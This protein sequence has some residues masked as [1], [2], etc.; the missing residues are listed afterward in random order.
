MASAIIHLAVCK[1][2]NETLNLNEREFFLGGIAPDAAKIVGVPRKTTHFCTDD[3]NSPIIN[4]FMKKYNGKL[5]DAFSIGFFV[6]LL[7]DVLWF[8][9]YRYNFLKD[10]Q[11]IYDKEGNL[12]KFTSDE[13]TELLYN[14]YTNMNSKILDAYNMDLSLFYETFDY[15][16]SIIE[17]FKD[18]YFGPLIN[19]MG[20]LASKYENYS[21]IL[22]ED[23][24][25]HF[26]EYAAIYC[27]DSL[28]KYN[29]K[30]PNL[31]QIKSI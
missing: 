8:S 19:K 25:I 26:I 6:H 1:K 3:D 13:I 12:L 24:I 18:S 31:D 9:D 11:H 20:I 17:E 14:D 5:N 28:K 2:V 22:K 15:P 4:D 16:H 10:E 29:I 7:T 23:S 21:Y 27:L 30:L